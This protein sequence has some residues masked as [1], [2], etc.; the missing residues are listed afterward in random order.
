MSGGLCLTAVRRGL[1][2][3]GWWRRPFCAGAGEPGFCFDDAKVGIRA[4]IFAFFEMLH[5]KSVKWGAEG[6]QG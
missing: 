6:L 2:C 4:K 3:G 5:V 1:G